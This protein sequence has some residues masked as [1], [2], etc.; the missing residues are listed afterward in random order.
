MGQLFFK[1]CSSKF[2][3]P[4]YALN[5]VLE[6]NKNAV[7]LLLGNNPLV[8]ECESTP[9]FQELLLKYQALIKDSNDINCINEDDAEFSLK[10]VIKNDL[11]NHQNYSSN[12]SWAVT[13]LV[14]NKS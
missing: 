14:V 9:I 5:N 4:S 2:K 6:R 10:P 11:A 13:A 3:I 7:R 1:V 8:C 12:E